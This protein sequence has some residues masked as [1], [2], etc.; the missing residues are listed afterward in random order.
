P[1]PARS[2]GSH[3]AP[4]PFASEDYMPHRNHLLRTAPLLAL[5]AG[6]LYLAV[7]CAQDRNAAG[8][9][10]AGVQPN[11]PP[12]AI[13][14]AQTTRPTAATRPEQQLTAHDRPENFDAN[15]ALPI[16]P[17]LA[18]QPKEGKISGFDFYRDPLNAD[19]PMTTF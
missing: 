10:A 1:C 12:D 13:Q 6:S 17:V 18:H 7:A 8:R 19:K 9:Q 5:A 3:P 2:H 15:H 11:V 16:S 14:S 4:H